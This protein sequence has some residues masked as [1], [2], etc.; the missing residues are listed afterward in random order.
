M[1]DFLYFCNMKRKKKQQPKQQVKVIKPIKKNTFSRNFRAWA[2][3]LDHRQQQRELIPVTTDNTERR[4]SNCSTVYTGRVCPQ[5]GQA[6]VWTRFTWR[7]AI[8]NLLDIWG[9]GNRPM[10]RTL[11][12]LFWRPG[13][14][15]RDYLQGQRQYYFPPFKL[16]AISVALTLFVG[17]MTGTPMESVFGD[18]GELDVSKYKLPAFFNSLAIMIVRFADFLSSNILYEWLFIGVVGVICVWLAFHRFC[19][20]NL[21]EIYIFLIFVLCQILIW[22]IPDVIGTRLCQ[23]V[24]AHTLVSG[25]QSSVSKFAGTAF[26]TI[27]DVISTIYSLLILFLIVMDFHQFFGLKWKTTIK[28][29]LLSIFIAFALVVNIYAFIKVGYGFKED[30]RMISFILWF[31]IWIP[32]CFIF[33]GRYLRKNK[34]QINRVVSMSCKVAILSIFLVSFVFKISNGF[35]L[36]I[37]VVL[38]LVALY[39]SATVALSLMPVVVYKKCHNTWLALLSLFMLVAM[40]AS[41]ISLH[42]YFQNN[43]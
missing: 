7:Q 43:L 27:A 37:P 34:A 33:V 39:F 4:C 32:A 41:I 14:M 15:A 3:R 38:I 35:Q 22:R 10:F 21:V 12:D 5:C 40:Q 42:H 11:R 8:L 24:E 36:A 18:L 31:I 19:K 25:T 9:L 20:Y 13:Y 6:G 1:R 29:L 2:L 26:L 30:V 16:L 28:R 23:F 17:W